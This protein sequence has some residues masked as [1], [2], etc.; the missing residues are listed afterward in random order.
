M[1]KNINIQEIKIVDLHGSINIDIP[2]HENKLILVAE[3]GA[4]KTTIVNI[5][6]F[7][8]SRQWSKL[9]EYNFKSI[10]AT[11]NDEKFIYLKKSSRKHSATTHYIDP[12]ILDYISTRYSHEKLRNPHILQQLSREFGI[13]LSAL[14]GIIR[15]ER[16]EEGF[17]GFET[18][19]SSELKELDK[20][21]KQI[22]KNHQFVYLPTYRRIEK[23]LKN[24][25]PD[26]MGS[27]DK[28][29]FRRRRRFYIEQP[30]YLE[31]VEFGMEDVKYLIDN[32]CQE[33][34]N[35]FYNNL[36]KKITGSYLEDILNK[37]YK[38]FDTRQLKK[39][40][41]DSLNYISKRL[42]DTLLSQE[43]KKNLKTFVT[44]IKNEKSNFNDEDRINAY[45]IWKLF[46]IYKVQQKAE[47][48]INKFVNICNSYLG[49]QKTFLYDNENSKIV[50]EL[51]DKKSG[52][53]SKLEYQDL[54]SGEKQIVSLFSHLCLSKKKF[55]IIIDE[56][57]LSISVPWQE[58]LLPDILSTT[59][60]LGMLAVTHSPFI[61]HNELKKFT[62]SLEEFTN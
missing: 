19:N 10:T 47:Q 50:I 54:S 13:P 22:F 42:D 16:F 20:R 35:N 33:L 17:E 43:G 31:L 40:T 11:I 27:M 53:K 36:S 32:R 44:E 18:T 55:Y 25:F 57:E 15:R 51:S 62:H 6:F 49:S 1:K 2:F 7:F 38:N 26:L 28:Y 41:D 59:D 37:K 3:N 4:G 39:V 12:D 45:F 24:I 46:E 21:L 8:L 29:E 58:K 23:D 61:F 30:N 60:C 9:N 34:K 56:P 48:D 14:Y 52:K 5:I